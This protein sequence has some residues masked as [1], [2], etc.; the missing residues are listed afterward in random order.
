MAEALLDLPDD[1]EDGDTLADW[2]EALML[3]ERRQ[4]ISSTE[5]QRRLGDRTESGVAVPLLMERVATRHGRAPSTYPFARIETGLERRSEIDSTLYELL[6]WSSWD[7]SPVRKA[8]NYREIDAAFDR[9]VLRAMCAYL[10]PLATGVRFGTPASEDRPKGFA[11]A[12][13]WLGDLMDIEATGTLPANDDKN[14]A[15]VD[16]IVWLPLPDARADFVVGI[17]QCTFRDAWPDKAVELAAAAT[18]WGGGWLA[19]GTKP[20]TFLAVPFQVQP[21]HAR[22][23]E[24]RQLVNAIFDRM[25]LCSLADSLADE[26]IADVRSWAD[27]VQ[28]A[29]LARPAPQGE[30]KG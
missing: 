23:L 10:G 21:T 22:Y 18:S 6:L 28:D 11:D 16:V 29:L 2:A 3:L 27:N 20:L 1:L 15:G 9:L 14:D 5:L 26:D 19:L 7:Q 12:L 4:E 30:A 24:L 13:V 8:H 17:A 25:R